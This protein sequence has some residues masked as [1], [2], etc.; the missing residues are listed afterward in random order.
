MGRAKASVPAYSW[1]LALFGG[2][3]TLA[4]S[5][6]AA[7]PLG[8][9]PATLQSLAVPVVGAALG[10]KRAG[11]ACVVYLAIGALGAPVFAEGASGLEHLTGPTAGYLIAFVPAAALAGWMAHRSNDLHLTGALAITLTATLLI[12]ALGWAWLAGSIG[13]TTAFERG[14]WPFLLAG[15]AKALIGAPLV[16]WVRTWRRVPKRDLFW[17]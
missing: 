13:A 17:D 9:V 16:L 11:L 15:V 1:V 3:T 6:W 7:I 8:S 12:L 10:W 14:V 4:L 5:S 2:P